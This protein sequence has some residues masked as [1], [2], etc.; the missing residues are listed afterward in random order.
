MNMGSFDDLNKKIEKPV[1]PLQFRP[2]F[3]VSGPA[4]WEE[5]KWKFVRIGDDVVFRTIQP[6]TRCMLT[7][8]D[9]MTGE[10]NKDEQP[11]KTLRKYRC[12]QNISK[13]SPVFGIHL[14]LRL[15]GIVK[16]GDPVYASY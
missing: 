4:A 7:T 12:F 5:D 11:I 2:N 15:P 16:S 10:R 9:P 8:I 3:V 13:T 1:G 6:C 14:G